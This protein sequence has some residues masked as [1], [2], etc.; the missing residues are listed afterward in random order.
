ML[1]N[2]P[3]RQLAAAAATDAA[4][5]VSLMAW[6][7]N[8]PTE[9]RTTEAAS[10]NLCGAQLST[11]ARKAL[12]YVLGSKEFTTSEST[13]ALGKTARALVSGYQEK[14]PD[15]SATVEE[16][17]LCTAYGPA[18]DFGVELS[19]Y[20]SKTVPAPTPPLAEVHPVRDGRTSSL[21]AAERVSLHEV[22]QW[23]LQFGRRQRVDPRGTDE[24]PGSEEP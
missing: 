3:V 19:F 10:S 15:D 22:L 20:P 13:T 17:E 5:V 2:R 1:S 7:S 23:L 16:Y 9:K 21:Q 24:P 12:L 8:E 11:G 6:D 18:A 14:G 4:L